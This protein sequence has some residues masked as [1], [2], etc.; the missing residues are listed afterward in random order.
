MTNSKIVKSIICLFLALVLVTASGVSTLAA[1]KAQLEQK[2]ADIKKKQSNLKSQLKSIR[3]DE[4]EAQAAYDAIME[5]IEANKEEINILNAYIVELDKEIADTKELIAKKDAEINDIYEKFKTRLRSLYMA[6]DMTGGLEMVLCADSFEDMLSATVYAQAMAKYDQSLIDALT[7]DREG[8]V[9]KMEEIEENKK[10][11]E[12]KKEEIAAKKAENDELAEEAKKKLKEI[13]AMEAKLEAL[14]AQYEKEMESAAAQI[15]YLAQ[16]ASAGDDTGGSVSFVL[17]TP[18]CYRIS[19]YFGKRTLLG[20]TRMHYGI[21]IPASG[22]S[23]IVSSASGTVSFVGYD[24]N[25]YGNYVMVSHG[26]GFVTV[27]GHMRSYCVSKGQKVVQ[28]QTIG[29]VGTTGRSTGN[30]LHFEIRKNGSAVN[31]LN[32]V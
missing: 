23:K 8:Y 30:H 1:T 18:S 32:Y 12:A 10:N 5:L 14:A 21:D 25:G 20:T 19:S 3:N 24:K 11:T 29:Y 4:K 2:Q 15:R 6:G 16:Q 27:Y 31:P 9:S 13:K 22:G 26:S 28:G 7:S 17:P